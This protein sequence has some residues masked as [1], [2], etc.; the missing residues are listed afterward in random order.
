[1]LIETEKLELQKYLDKFG[2]ENLEEEYGIKHVQSK[3]FPELYLFKYN[4]IKSPMRERIVQ[5][6]RGIILNAENEWVIVARSYDK[7]FNYKEE[8]A[9]NIDWNT[10]KIYE[11]LDGSIMTL[12]W[13][14]EKWRV[15]S[16]G[17]P[18]AAGEVWNDYNKTI[19]FK[20]LFWDTWNNLGYELPGELFKDTCFMFELMTPLNKVVITHKNCKLVLHGAR[21]IKINQEYDP[22]HVIKSANFNWNVCTSYSFRDIES[23]VNSANTIRGYEQE[24]YIVVDDNFKRVKIKSDEYV[25]LH[26]LREQLCPRKML[27]IVIKNEGSE[28][29]TYFPEFTEFYNKIKNKYEKLLNYINEFIFTWKNIKEER[30][31]NNK[32]LSRKEVG[33]AFK[34]KF[35]SGIIF[36]I[37]FE[38]K[39][40]E[41]IFKD[42]PVKKVEKWIKGLEK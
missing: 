32:E 36:P 38:N 6:S 11:K 10:S 23:V 34:D 3:V 1:M 41:E 4:Q 25:A 35:F 13:Y 9:E 2:I 27:E 30:E 12:Y 28:F 29:L 15:A 17:N 31:K 16:N 33:L 22:I 42:M 40:I 8:L 18:D 20:D 37:L 24:G 7:F 5:E 21:N 26:Y 14:K 39:N 19:T